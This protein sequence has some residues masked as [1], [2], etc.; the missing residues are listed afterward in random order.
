MNIHIPYLKKQLLKRKDQKLYEIKPIGS[1]IRYKRKQMNMTLEEACEGICSISYLSKL[2]NNQIEPGNRFIDQL[3]ERFQLHESFEID[4]DKYESDKAMMAHALLLEDHIG[5]DLMERYQHRD[6]YQ[7]YLIQMYDA[8]VSKN[9]Q[10]AMEK[11]NAIRG[12]VVNLQD[13]ELA[14][15]FQLTSILLYRKHRFSEAY[16]LLQDI[17]EMAHNDEVLALTTT[18]LKLMNAFR[19]HKQSEISTSYHFYLNKLIERH[20][21]HQVNKIKFAHMTYE[22]SFLCRKLVY[23]TIKKFSH[24]S[25]EDKDF[26]LAKSYYHHHDYQKAYELSKKHYMKNNKW[27]NLYL[28]IIDRMQKKEEILH[29]L[30]SIDTFHNICLGSE[31]LLMHLKFKYQAS[32]E[33]LLDYLRKSILGFNHITDEY[34]L[35]DYLMVDAIHLFS[36]H[37]FYKEAVMVTSKYLPRL[38][39]L[40]QAN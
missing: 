38:K 20:D 19:M 5:N 33:Q 18:K 34:H 26:A 11:Y 3:I 14:L 32:K 17:P 21:Y 24:L 6:D 13:D 7:A 12:Y 29:V 16:N 2:E 30:D 8:V 35:L 27:L 39:T 25:E 37:Q 23:K 15:F 1:A 28:M 31:I 36:K 40:N 10:T 9:M 4:N 22:A